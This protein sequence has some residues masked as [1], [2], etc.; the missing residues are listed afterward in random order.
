MNDNVPFQLT[1]DQ[2]L[3]ELF[4]HAQDLIQIVQLDGRLVY[5]NKSWS[6]VLGY[7]KDE[8]IGSSI[9]SFI[10]EPDQS[11]YKEYRNQV[12]EGVVSNKP[13]IFHLKSKSGKTIAVEGFVSNKVEDGK[14][15]YTR[16]IF[17]D[18]SRRLQNEK[19]LV[20]LN[21]EII[22][23]EKNLQQ[24]LI[25]A[26]DAVIVIN[27]ESRITFWNPKAEKMFGWSS[28]EVMG[29]PL[30]S[31][32]IPLHHRDAHVRGM[33]RY[34]TSGTET[35]L[36][37][38]IEITA[39]RKTGEEFYVSLSI[40]P[41]FQDGQIA[42]I[43]F[44]R[45]ITEQRQNQFELERKTKEIEQFTNVS[46]HDLQE[47]LRKIIM[48]AE[49]VKADSYHRLTEISKKRFQKISDAAFRMRQVLHD[50]LE[51]ASLDKEE[52]FVMVDLNE[53]LAAVQLDLELV[54]VEKHA[55]ITSDT[56]PIIKAIPH[57]IHQLFYNLLNN[58]LKFARTGVPAV[59]KITCAAPNRMDLADLPDAEKNKQ[60]YELIFRDNGIGLSPGD[61]EKIFGMFQRLHRKEAYPGT[62]IG[63]ALCQK[64]VGNH[65][66]KIKAESTPGEGA[67]FK[68]L[69]PA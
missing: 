11:V 3:R 34:L 68:V 47:P 58:A 38:T 6:D 45:D 37:K 2:W 14:V 10:D 21:E 15:L 51:F 40:S 13:L 67:I 62:G 61:T 57:Q 8:I 44:I 7:S 4:D 16:G 66:G 59:I 39:L 49:M 17:R 9:Y 26:P 20:L 63:L 12:I 46:H 52:D 43:A 55:S 50:I 30:Q 48:F 28:T 54:I 23:R 18:I 65:G 36:N 60:Y 69:L 29:Q 41:T 27:K 32:I 64:V 19:K 42:F 24:L 31:L 56:L 22:E 5:V 53:V 33:N 25:N 1:G 35:V